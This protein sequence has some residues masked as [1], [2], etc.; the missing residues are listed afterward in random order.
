MKTN[1]WVIGIVVLI[2]IGGVGSLLIASKKPSQS[3]VIPQI[4]YTLAEQT[5]IQSL[6]AD[7]TVEAENQQS[8]F[9]DVSGTIKT[10]KVKVG[11]SVKKGDVLMTLDTSKLMQSLQQAQYQLMV[12]Q[13]ALFDLKANGSTS[14]DANLERATSAYD[15]AKLDY[16]N[17]QILFG[18]GSISAADL[19]QSK[20][21]ME[22]AYADF[23]SA[24]D[25]K[26]STSIT[27][28]TDK[29]AAKIKLSQLTI[30]SIVATSD[31]Y[32]IIATMDGFI[33]E[34]EESL[35]KSVNSGEALVTI[36]DLNNLVI[37]SMISEYDIPQIQLGQSVNIT[38]L[39]NESTVYKG[40][41]LY[42]A[43]TG[44]TV[45][46][47]VLVEVKVSIDTPDLRLK[48]NFT[49]N[50]EIVLE[51]QVGVL[52]VPFDALLKEVNNQFYVM[53]KTPTG[54]AKIAVEKGLETDFNV[55]ILSTELKV[56]DVL[57]WEDKLA[58]A[59]EGATDSPS[60]LPK[61]APGPPGM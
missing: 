27:S 35:G 25:K 44:E 45:D 2:I 1:K 11:D 18:Q 31:T 47:E 60:L 3:E 39:G 12:D 29:L 54:N 51:E 53:K 36:S 15:Q 6:F 41:V 14:I 61:G 9:S 48:P 58:Q 55:Q 49:T 7:G 8:V 20:V 52:A 57:L 23:V 30:D 38:T 34:V 33:T 59:K 17:S 43:L 22:S 4:E 37:T 26:T 16:N 42:I 28:E 13:D 56:G 19:S 46:G 21:K 5:L 24:K 10:V 32:D 40:K 50:L